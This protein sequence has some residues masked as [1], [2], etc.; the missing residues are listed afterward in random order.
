MQGIFR[1]GEEVGGVEV[2]IADELKGRAVEG[3]C[4]RVGNDVDHS[5]GVH[6]VLRAKPRSFYAEL[7]DSIRERKRQVAIGHIVVVITAVEPPHSGIAHTARDGDGD[8]LIRVFATGE[9]TRWGRGRAS[10]ESD[11]ASHLASIERHL[12]H[13]LTVDGLLEGSVF[14]LE[15]ET[16]GPDLDL[17]VGGAY[18]HLYIDRN[19][20]ADFEDDVGLGIALETGVSDAKGICADRNIGKGVQTTI[21][22]IGRALNVSRVIGE[23]NGRVGNDGAGCVCDCAL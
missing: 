1:G 19:A 13:R 18:R 22:R 15:S 21:G 20:A 6:T 10:G 5:A 11:E 12:G 2:V 4:S 17:L 14:R 9:V 7:A 3:I 16:V 8:G 23:R